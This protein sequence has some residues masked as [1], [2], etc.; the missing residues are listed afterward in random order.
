MTPKFEQHIPIDAP[1]RKA[2]DWLAQCCATKAPELSRA[3]L[4]AVMQKGAVWLSRQGATQRLRRASRLLNSGDELHLYYDPQ[5]LNQP[6]LEPQLVADMGDYSVW[7]K[8]CGMLCQGSKYGDQTTLYRWAET[9]LEPERPAF[10]IHRLDRATRGLVLL[11]HNKRTAQRLSAL[12]EARQV[13]KY[14][15]AIVKGALQLDDALIDTPVDGKAA[16]SRITTLAVDLARDCSLIEV[17]LETGRKHQI[18][19]HLLSLGHPVLGDRFYATGVTDGCD[20]Q[21]QSFFL[22]FPWEQDSVVEY[23][24]ADAQLLM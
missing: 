10:I 1:G 2:I 14:Y 21:L 18:R 20:L 12:F 23:R 19:V 22:S 4:K 15:R 6:L 9:R 11:A 5:V 3:E 8:P 17:R 16:R 7:N 24:L 13:D